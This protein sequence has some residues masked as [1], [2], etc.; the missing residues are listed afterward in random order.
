M[1]LLVHFAF[2]LSYFTFF[3]EHSCFVKVNQN[4]AGPKHFIYIDQDKNMNDALSDFNMTEI[5]FLFKLMKR[6][7]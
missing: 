5:A 3:D 2:T 4:F 7:A 6:K 1:Q